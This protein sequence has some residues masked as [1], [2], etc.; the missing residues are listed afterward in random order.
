MVVFHVLRMVDSGKI[1]LDADYTYASASAK[2]E[3]RKIRDWI[4]PMVTLSDN[5]CTGALLKM[6]HDKNEIDNLNREFRELNLGTL[7][8]NATNPKNGLDWMPGQI[9][10]TAFDAVR[11][12]WIVDGA[13]G[14]LWLDAANQPVTA[15]YLSESSRAYLK[16]ELSDQAFNV[17]LSTADLTGGPHV[18][19]GIPSWA[20]T[21][22]INSTNGHVYLDGADYGVD[23]RE[24][25]AKAEV[26]FAHKTGWAFNSVSDAGIVTSLP[27]KPFRHYLIAFIANLGWR[28]AD[29][30]FADRKTFP[31]DDR[32][33]RIDFTQR[34]PAL[35]KA[36]DDGVVKLSAA[37]K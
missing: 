1:T 21:R 20:P 25:N 9:H 28:Y 16:K 29:E 7:Q 13:P 4:D 5:H 11:L 30:F 24:A 32:I 17:T 37:P 2:P 31:Y 35:G 19:A 36:I 27:G 33:G 10:M 8:I 23:I 12:L 22:W 15:Q 18:R 14:T 6:L 26:L 34:I 3:T